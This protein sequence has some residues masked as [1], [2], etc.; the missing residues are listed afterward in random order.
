MQS[1]IEKD[2]KISRQVEIS[3]TFDRINNIYTKSIINKNEI[4]K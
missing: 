4:N 1:D 3:I 2:Y